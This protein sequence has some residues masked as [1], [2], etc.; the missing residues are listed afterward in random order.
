MRL[1]IAALVLLLPA[2]ASADSSPAPLRQVT[3][4]GDAVIKVVP[5]Q[6][7]WSVG[8]S[9]N[10]STLAKAKARHDESLSDTLTYLKHLGSAIQGLQTG[11]IRFQKQEFIPKDSDVKPFTCATEITFT[12]TD[13]SQYGPIADKL[14][15]MDGAQIESVDYAYSKVDEVKRTALVQALGSAHDKANVLAIA[16][17]CYI[18]RPLS[19]TEGAMGNPQPLYMN[20]MVA[21]AAPM[22]SGT[23][24][25]S[26]GQLEINAQ[27]TVTYDLYYK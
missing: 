4:Q 11:G 22:M 27:V 18:D 14:S 16:S 6:M 3:V 2:L 20:R 12:L 10:D 15:Q 8:I 9:I 7:N 19:I 13:F 26:P 21:A 25:A 1:S 5:D 24:N 23:P 17:N